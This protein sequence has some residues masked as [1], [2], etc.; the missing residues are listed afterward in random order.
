[1]PGGFGSVVA[2]RADHPIRA[3]DKVLTMRGTL[4]L[5]SEANTQ[6]VYRLENAV[7]A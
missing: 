6:L 1:V 3:S 5:L 7:L 2:I 4:R